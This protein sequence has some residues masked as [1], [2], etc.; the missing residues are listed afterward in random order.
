MTVSE[1]IEYLKTLDGN[2][3]VARMGHFGEAYKIDK[4]D[5][6]VSTVFHQSRYTGN[7]EPGIKVL[8]IHP[9]DIGDEPD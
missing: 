8:A 5:F 1:L 4:Y 9:P 3:P 6:S 7:V 2:M